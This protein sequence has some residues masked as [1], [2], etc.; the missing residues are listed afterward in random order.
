[1]VRWYS[2]VPEG[3]TSSTLIG[4]IQTRYLAASAI[5]FITS[6]DIFALVDKIRIIAWQLAIASTIELG[7]SLPGGISLGA[8]Q[9]RVSPFSRLRQIASAASLSR[10]EWLMNTKIGSDGVG[11]GAG[12]DT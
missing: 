5:S 11:G 12:G 3:F 6:V 2:K 10:V 4:I 7:Q 1:M 8:I 9:Q